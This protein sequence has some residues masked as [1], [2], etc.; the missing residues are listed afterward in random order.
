MDVDQDD[1]DTLMIES[2]PMPVLDTTV[3]ELTPA[4]DALKSNETTAMVPSLDIVTT[5]SAMVPSP[6]IEMSDPV[7]PPPALPKQ[8]THLDDQC[9]SNTITD[10]PSC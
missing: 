7:L 6:D 9:L 1:P 10:C 3:H 8:I 2:T 4:E 5:D